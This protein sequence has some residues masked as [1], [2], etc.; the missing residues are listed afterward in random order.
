MKGKGPSKNLHIS[1]ALN[2]QRHFYIS[3]WEKSQLLRAKAKVCAV[4]N[5]PGKDT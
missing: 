3:N 4:C 2:F 1:W 5:R